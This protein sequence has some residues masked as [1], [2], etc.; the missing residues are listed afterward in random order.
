[1]PVT[2]MSLLILMAFLHLT[3]SVPPLRRRGEIL[4]QPQSLLALCWGQVWVK[5][6]RQEATMVVGFRVQAEPLF[7]FNF[8]S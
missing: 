3:L 1:M 8:L 4:A 6:S 7:S 2:L 5:T